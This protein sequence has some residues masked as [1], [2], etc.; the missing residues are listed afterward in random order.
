MQVKRYWMMVLETSVCVGGRTAEATRGDDGDWPVECLVV[1][2]SSAS[3][4]LS[5]SL[6]QLN[7]FG[8]MDILFSLGLPL[9]GISYFEILYSLVEMNRTL[10][11]NKFSC[12]WLFIRFK[13]GSS[14]YDLFG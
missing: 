2:V 14:R 11:D 13:F 1:A 4:Y 3:L 5:P 9:T 8:R 10:K 7:V 12:Y 6:L